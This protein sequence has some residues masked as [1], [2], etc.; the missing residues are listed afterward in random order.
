MHTQ[1]LFRTNSSAMQRRCLVRFGQFTKLS[2]WQFPDAVCTLALSSK[3]YGFWSTPTSCRRRSVFFNWSHT[4]YRRE[5]GLLFFG[6]CRLALGL[7]CW[8]VRAGVLESFFMLCQ[9][10]LFPFRHF[11]TFMCVENP[12]ENVRNLLIWGF[13]FYIAFTFN[14]TDASVK[15]N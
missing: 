8:E 9:P 11:S 5:G 4:A 13:S 3:R 2:T 10:I 1:C 15:H 14:I 12:V 7:W 6:S